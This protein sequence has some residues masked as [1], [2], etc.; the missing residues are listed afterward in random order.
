[1]DKKLGG[2][3]GAMEKIINDPRNIAAL[4]RPC[5]DLLHRRRKESYE[6]ERLGVLQKLNAGWDYDY[7]SKEWSDPNAVKIMQPVVPEG[8]DQ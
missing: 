3:H 4:C 6:G 2:R 7:G 5:H 8:A 1:M